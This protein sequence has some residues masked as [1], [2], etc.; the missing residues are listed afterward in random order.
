MSRYAARDAFGASGLRA[1]R[2]AYKNG[3]GV[4]LSPLNVAKV[5]LNIT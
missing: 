3:N 4:R 5:F 2:Y 1:E